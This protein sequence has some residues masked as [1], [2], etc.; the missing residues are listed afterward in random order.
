MNELTT[1]KA[2]KDY[3]DIGEGD[4]SSDTRLCMLI[5]ASSLH[6]EVYCRRVFE[7]V[8]YSETY[9]GNACD[10]LFVKHTPITAVWTLQQDGEGIAAEDFK[11]YDDYLRLQQSLFTPGELNVAVSYS[12]GYYD[13]SKG[14]SPPSDVE[15]ACIQL[16]AF[17]YM[18]RQS[19]D[20]KDRSG[21]LEGAALPLSVAIILDKY[22][23]Y[24]YETN[25]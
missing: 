9:D 21:G 5:E 1:L 24:R 7:V 17:K 8:N 14:E 18:F 19:S 10:I 6:C 16:V 23:R 11:F 20:A 2:V 15:D 4:T 13:P 12:A 25:R 22:R 3:L